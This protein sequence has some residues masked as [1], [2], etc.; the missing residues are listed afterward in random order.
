MT[1][2]VFS[3][4]SLAIGQPC[5]PCED[6]PAI[7]KEILKAESVL[8][9]LNIKRKSIYNRMNHIHDP[10]TSKLPVELASKI[11]TNF[12][13]DIVAPKYGPYGNALVART[14]PL[15]LGAVCTTWRAIAW[16]TPLLWTSV[17]VELY[18]LENANVDI[19]EGWL[20][21][22]GGLPLYICICGKSRYSMFS[23]RG[24]VEKVMDL[25][26]RYAHRWF[27]LEFVSTP[28]NFLGYLPP[29][30]GC[31]VMLNTLKVKVIGITNG[32]DLGM[33]PNLRNL[34]MD[35]L[36]ID[37]L[38]NLDWERLTHVEASIPSIDMCYDLFSK[39][40]SLTHCTLDLYPSSDDLNTTWNAVLQH[41][42]LIFLRIKNWRTRTA[43]VL[44]LM[45]F[46]ALQHLVVDSRADLEN[47]ISLL[48]RSHCS[49]KTLE[50]DLSPKQ[51]E[52]EL[53]LIPFLAEIL[54]L[55]ILIFRCRYAPIGNSVDPLLK[56]L[57]TTAHIQGTVTGQ[58][59][60]L[61]NLRTLRIEN[62]ALSYDQL[63][64][65]VRAHT[66]DSTVLTPT[67]SIEGSETRQCIRPLQSLHILVWAHKYRLIELDIA[68][69][70][71]RAVKDGFNITIAFDDWGNQDAGL[72]DILHKSLHPPEA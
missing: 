39:S 11:F 19:L 65:V 23:I 70:L 72:T 34:A 25:F 32:I 1:E 21:R 61:P 46:P 66:A 6:L 50:V 57:S 43:I 5:G 10:L 24:T 69:K 26:A 16:S 49:L 45:K 64:D 53:H 3:C 7:N 29:D 48:R 38:L 40:P 44:S 35:Y 27:Y 31:A 37:M 52:L 22:S 41:D 42:H 68:Q 58:F 71:Q 18:D 62:M 17:T 54:S 51:I 47:I 8:A 60:L 9:A 4:P 12:L 2:H 20:C 59:I 67:R 55:E 13:P 36:Q 56:L 63:I 14:T 15:V 30:L 33:I 28:D